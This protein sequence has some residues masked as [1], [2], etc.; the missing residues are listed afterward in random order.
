MKGDLVDNGF[1]N[2]TS[3]ILVITC[4]PSPISSLFISHERHG[5][6][7]FR[8][9]PCLERKIGTVRN[10]NTL[11]SHSDRRTPLF[12]R[13]LC[14]HLCHFMYPCFARVMTLSLARS[15]LWSSQKPTHLTPRPQRKP[16]NRPRKRPIRCR[17]ECRSGN[18][19]SLS[20]VS[21]TW[22]GIEGTGNGNGVSKTEVASP[23]S[24]TPL[25]AEQGVAAIAG[26][27][28]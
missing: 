24:T 1:L 7:L 19:L 12:P 18:R 4:V 11:A 16:F 28:L 21:E 10:W 27:V 5:Y 14:D 3:A 6:R 22:Y 20:N 2:E 8:I 25:H 9:S 13:R 26:F 17:V 15:L 23:G